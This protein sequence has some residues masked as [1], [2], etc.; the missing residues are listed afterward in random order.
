[1]RQVGY[2]QGSY[3]DARS[4]KHKKS[5]SHATNLRVG[6]VCTLAMFQ[7]FGAPLWAGRLQVADASDGLKMWQIIDNIWNIKSLTIDNGWSSSWWVWRGA[8]NYEPWKTNMFWHITQVLGLSDFLWSDFVCV[9]KG[10][11]GK[12]FEYGDELSGF[13]RCVAFLD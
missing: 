2:L 7:I 1:M 11:K 10:I 6:T 4:T 8:D 9:R 3:R 13:I 5:L 12:P